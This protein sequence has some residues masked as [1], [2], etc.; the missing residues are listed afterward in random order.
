MNDN[1]T[2][3][4]STAADGVI[5]QVLGYFPTTN[6]DTAILWIHGFTDNCYGDRGIMDAMRPECDKRGWGFAALNTRGHDMVASIHRVDPTAPKGHTSFTGG[7]E[8]EVFA[9]CVHDIDA[10]ITY[11]TGRGFSKVLL[12]GISTGANKAC[13]YMGKTSD[14]RV[15]GVILASPLSDVPSMLTELGSQYEEVITAMGKRDGMSLVTDHGDMPM[16]V[17]RFLS[18]YGKGSPEDVFPYYDPARTPTSLASIRVP[19]LVTFGGNDEYADRPVEGILAWFAAHQTSSRYRGAV[20]PG[21]FHSY[22]GAEAAFVSA[23]VSWAD[24]I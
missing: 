14:P 20:I 21:G 3:T 12:A 10:G 5:L 4:D 22:G 17:Q 1:L 16:T 6:G 19:L 11:L 15:S 9:D 2:F 24:S 18:M 7:A 8:Y 23:V 13:Y